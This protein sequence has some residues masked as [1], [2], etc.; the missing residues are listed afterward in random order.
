M[1]WRSI[2]KTGPAKERRGI[3]LEAVALIAWKETRSCAEDQLGHRVGRTRNETDLDGEAKPAVQRKG[4]E[5]Y[6][7]RRSG[8]AEHRLAEELIAPGCIARAQL[9]K[10]KMG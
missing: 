2:D 5:R 3:E 8:I 4:Y 10:A 1:P 6:T 7:K 9:S